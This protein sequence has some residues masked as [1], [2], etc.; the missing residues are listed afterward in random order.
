MAV[1]VIVPVIV[2]VVVA[3]GVL[4]GRGTTG[5]HRAGPWGCRR[6]GGRWW[7]RLLPASAADGADE[8]LQDADRECCDA[9]EHGL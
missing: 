6:T 1:V 2:P 3:V 8:L 5:R 7:R 9:L 4:L